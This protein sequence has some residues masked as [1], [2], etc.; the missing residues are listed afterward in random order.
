M[1]K[2]NSL[3]EK[4]P[5]NSEIITEKTIPTATDTI[6]FF[7]PKF[8]NNIFENDEHKSEVPKGITISLKKPIVFLD[9]F[10]ILEILKT[11]FNIAET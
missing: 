6:L 3:F 10:K 11:E 5:K 8:K 1:S 2:L 9:I 7:N 4:N